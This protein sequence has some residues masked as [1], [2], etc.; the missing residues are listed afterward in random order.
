MSGTYDTDKSYVTVDS[1]GYDATNKKLCLKVDGADTVV[2]FNS[3]EYAEYE[4]GSV[5]VTHLD[6]S[7]R[8]TYTINFKHTFSRVPTV[9]FRPT[10]GLFGVC[11]PSTLTTTKCSGYSNS[12]RAGSYTLYY[13]AFIKNS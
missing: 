10:N 3:S 8:W 5:T 13:M 1:I 11:A 4:E 7:P 12:D 9:Y 6:T 2:P